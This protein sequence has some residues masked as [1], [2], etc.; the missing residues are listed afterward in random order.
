[1]GW[2]AN[3][4]R[5]W[6]TG[7]LWRAVGF[8]LA[9]A[10]LAVAYLLV[11]SGFGLAAGLALIGV[12]AP[13]LWP[14]SGLCTF[15]ASVEARRVGWVAGRR[16]V[17]PQ[18]SPL[19]PAPPEPPHADPVV[20]R[21]VGYLALALLLSALE[22]GSIGSLI[23]CLG[24]LVLAF[25]FWS[26]P[27]LPVGPFNNSAWPLHAV[28]EAIAATV[29]GMIVACAAP[30]LTA[31]TVWVHERVAH[32]MLGPSPRDQL[33]AQVESLTESR[34]RAVDAAVLERRRI[35]R[36]LHDGAQQ[37]LVALALDL[38]MARR[39]LESD[40]A[41]AG[42]LVAEAHEEAKRALAEIRDLAR[43][44]HPAV[45]T[46]RGLD[47]AFSALAGRC[48]VPVE[49][50]VSFYQRLPEAVESAAY[51]FVAEALTNIARHSRASSA[52]VTATLQGG[53]LVVEVRDD[54][55]GGASRDRGT[56]LR[57]L[58]DRLA[59]LDGSLTLRS[60]VGGPTV[61]SMDV[62]CG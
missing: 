48:S 29:V 32:R 59:A 50:N 10:P 16:P 17:L 23:W 21:T 9:G 49:I 34:S 8:S 36:D 54:G 2:V 62:P 18:K 15:I 12:R 40:P 42:Q 33:A 22:L 1:M 37:R 43:G 39:K 4:V 52:E 26:S 53:R 58:A 7:R 11:V 24:A 31:S 51:F 3:V 14:W 60:P 56:G 61:V 35:E 19:S 38:G 13:L 5:I 28:P 30:W 55:A 46:D 47:A 45:L 57:G 6:W 25:Q 27:V 41:A 44:I 20:R